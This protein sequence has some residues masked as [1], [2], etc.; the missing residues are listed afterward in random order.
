[1]AASPQQWK[2]GPRARAGLAQG[3]QHPTHRTPAQKVSSWGDAA[4]A[5]APRAPRLGRG[6]SPGASP[7]GSHL[8]RGDVASGCQVL[9]EKGGC[10]RH[11]RDAE[12]SQT[13][14]KCRCVTIN[15]YGD[16]WPTSHPFIRKLHRVKP[17]PSP[18]DSFQQHSQ[19]SF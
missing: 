3:T 6:R 18:A 4:P 1:M 5:P 19:N 2:P 7:E 12:L 14:D 9:H 8:R 16:R 10:H 15:V 11:R 13:Q 17:K